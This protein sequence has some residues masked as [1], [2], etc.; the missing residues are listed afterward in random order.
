MLTEKL[1][2]GPEIPLP[3]GYSFED[4][5]ASTRTD[6][7]VRWCAEDCISYRDI[8]LVQDEM[9]SRIPDLPLPE[10]DRNE[11]HDEPVV[12]GHYTLSGAPKPLSNR[13]VCVNYNAAKGNN[14]LVSYEW[15]RGSSEL[16]EHCFCYSGFPGS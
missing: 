7:R 3:T 11:K 5:N 16:S 1:L 9:K 6:I 8:A 12:V 15:S 2:M 4:K 10:R 13:V 14:P